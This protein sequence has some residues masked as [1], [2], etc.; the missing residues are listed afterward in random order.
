MEDSIIVG[1]VRNVAI[2]L[3]FSILYDNFWLGRQMKNRLLSQILAGLFL[4]MIVIVLIITPWDF[5]DGIFFDTR[6]VLLAISGLFFGPIPTIIAMFISSAYRIYV[7]GAGVFMGVAVILLSGTMGMI[8]NRF[9]TLSLFRNNTI[10]LLSLG[11]I[12]HLLMLSCIFLLPSNYQLSTFKTILFAVIVLYPLATLLLGRYILKQEETRKTKAALVE[13]ELRWK[14]ALEGTGDGIWDWDLTTNKVFF[15]DNWKTMLGYATSEIQHHLSEWERLVHPD[16]IEAA[17]AEI[18]KH[19]SGANEVYS[20]EFR[21]RCK[22]GSYKW[23]LDNGKVI[24]FDDQQKPVRFIGTHKDISLRKENE[25]KLAN[26]RFLL[27]SLMDFVPELIYFKDLDS[28][29]I[30]V[31][32]ALVRHLGCTRMEEVIGKTD[33]DFFSPEFAAYAYEIEQNI[34]NT[35]VPYSQEELAVKGDG[36]LS[37]GISSKL[38]LYDPAGEVIGTFGL[39]LDINKQKQV[40]QALKASERYTKSILEAIPDLIFVMDARGKY[41]DFKSGNLEELAVPQEHFMFKN[42]RDVLPADIARLIQKAIDRTLAHQKKTTIEYELT[43]KDRLV[44][45]ECVI[46]PFENDRVISLARDVTQRKLSEK[47]LRASQKQLKQ[48]AAHLQNV[49]E[50]ERVLLSREIHDELGQILIALKIDIGMFKQLVL[51][52]VDSASYDTLKMKYDAILELVDKTINTTR[53]IMTGLRP[54]TIELVGFFESARLYVSEFQARY[55]IDCTFQTEDFVFEFDEQKAIAFFRILQE[56]LSNVAKHSQATKVD[57]Q[58]FCESDRFVMKIIDN[59][60]GIDT[61][62]PMRNDAYGLL[63]MKERVFLLDGVLRFDKNE[64]GGTIVVVDIPVKSGID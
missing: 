28:R 18:N 20:A 12:V 44:Y 53:R 24:E 49:R 47:E 36:Q 3:T 22:D 32:N 30:R 62:K 55:N 57:V 48:F 10:S 9:Q 41:L 29:F 25:L 51:K 19:L 52:H 16:D 15:S 63:G 2:L 21:M 17:Y 61:S 64:E 1:L 54:S 42:I 35:K 5:K 31:N 60:I 6:S 8:W 43:I 26:E 46:I 39:S 11:I 7:G 56:A 45:F 59:G 33:F 50:E 34:I 38:P 58:M 40:E 27:E 37:W 13:S 23:I 14:F 4:G